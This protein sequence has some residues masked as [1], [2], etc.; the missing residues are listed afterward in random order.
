MLG[1][2]IIGCGRITEYRHAPEYHQNKSATIM[3]FVDTQSS[4]ADLM[5]EKFGGK[6]YESIGEMLNDP[7]I[8][9][10][11]VCVANPYHAEVTL[12]ALDAGKHV[13]LE[14]PM[15]TTLEDCLSIASK[16]KSKGN[17][18]ML[19]HNQRFAPAHIKAKELIQQGVIGK[20]LG[21]R[22]TF[23]HEGPEV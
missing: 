6:T 11:S 21:F 18:V 19:G 20:P 9:A 23:G 22:V 8:D 2:G 16:A 5:V 1:I 14:K 15:A 17:I 13:L 12:A 10:V 7:A 3:G 4:R